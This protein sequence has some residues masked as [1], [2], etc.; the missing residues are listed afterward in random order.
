MKKQPKELLI[1]GVFSF[2]GALSFGFSIG[3]FHLWLLIPAA[4]ITFWYAV[5]LFKY[6]GKRISLRSYPSIKISSIAFVWTISTVLFPLQ[7]NLTDWQV[8]LEFVQR[9]FLFITLII[10]FDIRDLN[11]DAS[12]LQTLPQKIGIAKVKIVGIQC[13]VLFFILGFFKIPLDE[14]TV[15]S[16]L[17]VFILSLLL[18]KG[19]AN[20]E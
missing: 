4:F 16:E 11:K 9:F 12:H 17:L 15:V 10:P 13:L 19:V 20:I 8:Y 2:V 3:I 14:T 18:L 6:K 7:E 1:V 5:P